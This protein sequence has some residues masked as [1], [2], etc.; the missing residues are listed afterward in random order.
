M[1]MTKEHTINLQRRK[2]HD[3]LIRR[4]A[5]VYACVQTGD[6]CASAVACRHGCAGRWSL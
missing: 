2:L 5:D 1:M 3:H 4:A 6:R